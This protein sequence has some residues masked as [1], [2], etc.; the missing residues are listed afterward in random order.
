MARFKTTKEIGDFLEQCIH[1]RVDSALSQEDYNGLRQ[2]GICAPDIQIDIGIAL[3]WEKVR[4][5]PLPEKFPIK[6][7]WIKRARALNSAFAALKPQE[8]DRL[9]KSL[10]GEDVALK[11]EC[12]EATKTCLLQAG[13]N[14]SKGEFTMEHPNNNIL[15][16]Y[17]HNL[18]DSSPRVMR[19]LPTFGLERVRRRE[20]EVNPFLPRGKETPTKPRVPPQPIP[21][22]VPDLATF[23]PFFEREATVRQLNNEWRELVWEGLKELGVSEQGMQE[24]E[25]HVGMVDARVQAMADPQNVFN[26]ALGNLTSRM[27][28]AHF[29]RIEQIL[30]KEMVREVGAAEVMKV[31]EEQNDLDVDT[32]AKHGVIHW[33]RTYSKQ[34]GLNI[35]N[36]LFDELL[37]EGRP[38]FGAG[39]GEIEDDDDLP[40]GLPADSDDESEEQEGKQEEEER[41]PGIP[42]FVPTPE[43][44]D[45]I[46]MNQL[47]GIANLVA[48]R[49]MTTRDRNTLTA[50]INWFKRF[51]TKL[52]RRTGW[53]TVSML[54]A[55]FV[56]MVG[57]A[58]YEMNYSVGALAIPFLGFSLDPIVRETAVNI[59]QELAS[60]NQWRA[61]GYQVSLKQ[62]REEK[63]TLANKAITL[64]KEIESARL[65]LPATQLRAEELDKELAPLKD[66][67]F[68]LTAQKPE[69]DVL[70]S[71]LFS[72]GEKILENVSSAEHLRMQTILELWG[73]GGMNL[74]SVR[75]GWLELFGINK[76]SKEQMIKSTAAL[77]LHLQRFLHFYAGN[78][79]AREFGAMLAAQ[80]SEV[81]QKGTPDSF[82]A[83]MAEAI[84]KTKGAEAPKLSPEAEK[85]VR[86]LNRLAGTEGGAF[87][88][89]DPNVIAA[90]SDLQDLGFSLLLKDMEQIFGPVPSGSSWFLGSYDKD[91]LVDVLKTQVIEKI[92]PIEWYIMANVQE[93]GPAILTDVEKMG[94]AIV[95]QMIGATATTYMDKQVQRDQA[96]A[97]LATLR[98]KLAAMEAELKV[99]KA[100]S[101]N[102][103]AIESM[104]AAY[105]NANF[106]GICDSWLDDFRRVMAKRTMGGAEGV[107]QQYIVDQTFDGMWS[108][109]LQGRTWAANGLSAVARPFFGK[110][111]GNM[112]GHYSAKTLTMVSGLDLLQYV[113][114]YYNALIRMNRENFA[115]YISHAGISSAIVGWLNTILTGWWLQSLGYT[116]SFAAVVGRFLVSRVRRPGEWVKKFSAKKAVLF[117]NQLRSS[118]YNKGVAGALF[119]LAMSGE[120]LG[121]LWD[122]LFGLAETTVAIGSPLGRFLT[123]H[124]MMVAHYYASIEAVIGLIAGLNWYGSVPALHSMVSLGL[125]L[126]YV[127]PGGY[128]PISWLKTASKFWSAE[129]IADA[130]EK[131]LLTGRPSVLYSP[132][133][134]VQPKIPEILRVRYIQDVAIWFKKEWDAACDR[135]FLDPTARGLPTALAKESGDWEELWREAKFYGWLVF[136]DMLRGYAFGGL[137][138]WFSLVDDNKWVKWFFS[139]Y[140]LAAD[141]LLLSPELLALREKMRP[142]YPIQARS[143]SSYAM[144]FSKGGGE[145][146][147]LALAMAAKGL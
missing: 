143:L 64:Q 90:F 117:R 95:D 11:L 105:D 29:V 122:S 131:A 45:Q 101:G 46:A 6:M 62:L 78:P 55:G 69:L 65:H 48:E 76:P 96:H 139:Y 5:D 141:N 119:G 60:R 93:R 135:Q 87:D 86:D 144:V 128:S 59:N 98:P 16:I 91:R 99:A 57:S 92:W 17:Y 1:K 23:M 36:A 20:Q 127:L 52:A 53:V 8:S 10:L 110:D 132:V 30:E 114:A 140:D 40:P 133:S 79:A 56:L 31:Q 44:D 25:A 134:A 83:A 138:Y 32:L 3:K 39:N 75:D 136:V 120:A 103:M 26:A 111:L 145:D 18:S 43:S 41:P 51:I 123:K 104:V 113:E 115:R 88:P 108:Y 9:Y 147:A 7:S 21:Q 118:A 89:A 82:A 109:T 2:L 97:E 27:M 22:D 137:A 106:G 47:L 38:L 35:D 73:P 63:I 14:F 66:M 130:V 58:L 125:N 84:E 70:G 77:Q 28:E 68:L 13:F 49:P 72:I 81:Y 19:R 146:R 116:V 142:F 61:P 107:M 71:K 42:S 12:D 24:I 4:Q 124:G 100:E 15:A 34:R 102:A 126:Q 80:R 67:D 54:V 50:V 37:Q 94:A 85:L 121:E 74:Q 112:L 33:M 129:P